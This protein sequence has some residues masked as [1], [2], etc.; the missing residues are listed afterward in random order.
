MLFLSP[1]STVSK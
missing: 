1:T